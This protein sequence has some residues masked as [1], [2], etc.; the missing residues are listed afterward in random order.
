MSETR[1]RTTLPR[2]RPGVDAWLAGAI[3]AE[4]GADMTRSAADRSPL[5]AGMCREQH[6]SA[7]ESR[8]GACATADSWLRGHPAGA[9]CPRPAR[10]TRRRPPNTTGRPARQ[11]AS[12]SSRCCR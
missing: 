2:V 1:R 12:G 9:A 11:D 6:E 8:T 5:W 10:K 4:I 7:G 3:T